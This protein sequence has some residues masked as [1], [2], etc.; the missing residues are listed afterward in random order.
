MKLL[1]HKFKGPTIHYYFEDA[2]EQWYIEGKQY[3]I[4]QAFN[5]RLKELADL[6]QT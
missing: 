6:N 2:I 5:Q 1:N 3:P 4:E